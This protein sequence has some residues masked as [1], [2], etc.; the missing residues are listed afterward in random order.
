MSAPERSTSDRD[1]ANALLDRKKVK[2]EDLDR[3]LVQQKQL[4]NEQHQH[5]A[6][7]LYQIDLKTSTLQVFHSLTHEPITAIP[8]TENRIP[9]NPFDWDPWGTHLLTA[10]PDE[11]TQNSSIEWNK[12]VPY[13]LVLTSD[14]AYAD[15]AV[16]WK[17]EYLAQTQQFLYG[18]IHKGKPTTGPYDM[19]LSRDRKLL[20]VSDRGAGSVTIISTADHSKKGTVRVRMVGGTSALNLAID[21]VA[22]RLFITDNQSPTLNIV[23]LKTMEVQKQKL[24]LGIVGNLVLAP[25]N[26]HLFILTIK[27]NVGLAY[28]DTTSFAVEKNVKL[29]GDLFSDSS[30]APCDLLCLA[31]DQK[32][33]LLMTYL[34]EPS[35]FTP[36]ISVLDAAQVKTVRRYSIKDESK[37]IQ[38]AFARPNPTYPYTKDLGQLLLDAN[39]VSAQTLWEVKLE[40]RSG[41]EVD[42]DQAN[43]PPPDHT[44]M[45]VEHQ[46]MDVAVVQT[47][48]ATEEQPLLVPHKANKIAM[49]QE[50]IPEILDILIE[51][52]NHQF[53]ADIKQHPE[54]FARLQQEAERVRQQL[55]EYD[56]VIVQLDKLLQ[57]HTLRTVVMRDSIVMMLEI[58]DS[59]RQGPARTPPMSC[60]SC[61]Q[62]LLGSWE[63]D[64]CGFELE[65]PE[66]ALKRRLASADALV[67]LPRGHFLIPAPK[68]VQLLQ[69]NPYKFISWQLDS[70]QLS[71]N[72]PWD[73]MRLPSQNLLVVDKLGHNVYEI[74]SKGKIFWNVDTR[75]SPRHRLNG[76]VKA[77][78]YL[79][80]ETDYG[81]G[82]TEHFLIVDRGNHRVFAIDRQQKIQWHYGSQGVPGKERGYLQHPNDVQKTHTNTYLIADTGNNRVIEIERDDIRHTFGPELGLNAPTFAQRLFDEHTIICDAGNY[83][84]LEVDS[85]DHI[86]WECLYF[87]DE[88]PPEYK[89]AHPVKMIRR[90]NRNILLSDESR[91]LEIIPTQKKMVWFSLLENLG[92]QPVYT[93]ETIAKEKAKRTEL[94]HGNLHGQE[95]KKAS[96]GEAIDHGEIQKVERAASFLNARPAHQTG[97]PV[98]DAA[99]KPAD[100]S[101]NILT[102]TMATRKLKSLIDA[103]KEKM[104]QS[105][106]TPLVVNPQTADVF[107][108][109]GV[110]LQPLQPLLVDRNHNSLIRIT[111]Q[112]EIQWHYGFELGQSLLRPHHVTETEKTVLVA[113]T[114][115][116]R[117][118]EIAK[119]DKAIIRE[120]KGSGPQ[121]LSRPRSAIR[122]HLGKT[123]V[124]DQQNK[125]LFEYDAD[126]N[127][128]WEY[129]HP[130]DLVGP[131]Y[132]E[133]LETG[134]LLYTDALLHIVREM[135]REGNTI[136]VYGEKVSGKGPNQLSGPEFATRLWTDTTLI[137]DTR[138]HRVIE[139]D[140][141]GQIIWEY[142]GSFKEKMLNPVFCQRMVDG[143][144]LIAHNNYRQMVEVDAGGQVVWS[145]QMSQDMMS[146]L[147]GLGSSEDDLTPVYNDL[148]RSVIESAASEGMIAVEIYIHL[149]RNCQMKSVRASLIMM[150]LERVGTVIR[151]FPTSEDML[152]E[153]IGQQMV[154]TIITDQTPEIVQDIVASIAEVD[155]VDV[156]LATA[157]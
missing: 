48:S 52:F 73:V 38:L 32:H 5:I 22:N 20:C 24:G 134:H 87:N 157:E 116:N 100:K 71:C 13:G 62:P 90:E 69:I 16:H 114:G 149:M 68:A 105:G 115:N 59:L 124:A 135:D 120:Y 111:R 97:A 118:L 61:Q 51:T 76:P 75:L 18:C 122:I 123:L 81:D 113:D 65:S 43:A 138:N 95:A 150:S 23:N 104:K 121:A 89:I 3:V 140:G 50:A 125:R 153:K 117:I 109:D 119:S 131:Y 128:S 80:E 94:E 28:V 110:S 64:T 133:E 127:M 106:S 154:L 93:E 29:K 60:P 132:V 25:D 21:S 47:P 83:R 45:E 40:L 82:E 30:N 63:C 33:L 156:K 17:I 74:G 144:T 103:R 72:M 112:G 108:K 49:S 155:N 4:F 36:I 53:Q 145:F 147:A 142:S 77:T 46:I 143:N 55:E 91:I 27:P 98:H 78:Y 152:A 136:W 34:N 39:L 130:T 79:H 12:D 129:R 26:K 1:L 137:A 54:D 35:P 88:M 102:Q 126:G 41:E 151:T 67:N 92:T 19:Y 2:I 107:T 99:H 66:R 141:G 57:K 70:E 148:E 84:L 56:S 15:P 37:P 96:F 6:G 10:T 58:K 31:P 44:I 139:V 101:A 7:T 85:N 8:L 9:Y 14:M 86:V 42:R 11:G 146:K